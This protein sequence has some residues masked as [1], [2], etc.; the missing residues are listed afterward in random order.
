LQ[1]F[2]LDPLI[3]DRLLQ[4]FVGKMNRNH[5]FI[6]MKADVI[7]E[8]NDIIVTFPRRAHNPIIKAAQLDKV[9]TPISW[10][11]NRRMIYEFR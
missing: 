8:G 10:L 11:G 3:L 1:T 4:S 7:I 5:K 2:R 9:S 6:N